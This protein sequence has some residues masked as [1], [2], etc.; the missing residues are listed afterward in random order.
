MHRS[1]VLTKEKTVFVIIREELEKA[2]KTSLCYGYSTEE[3]VPQHTT[4]TAAFH[5]QVY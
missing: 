3:N 1:V 5:S 4:A 2:L